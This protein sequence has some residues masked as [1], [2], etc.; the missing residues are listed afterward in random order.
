MTEIRTAAIL[1]LVIKAKLEAV[2]VG[3]MI[4]KE[5]FYGTYRTS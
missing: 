5:E 2:E 4:F 3:I 1:A